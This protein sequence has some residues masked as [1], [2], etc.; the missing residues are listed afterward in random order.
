M[1][2]I[3]FCVCVREREFFDFMH[4]TQADTVLRN[5]SFNYKSNKYISS[6]SGKLTGSGATT[7]SRKFCL[8][9]LWTSKFEY[10][11]LV[12]LPL[13]ARIQSRQRW[14]VRSK[15]SMTHGVSGPDTYI[16]PTTPGTSHMEYLK[17]W[18]RAHGTQCCL[19]KT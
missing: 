14:A 9:G 11:Y 3:K 4:G 18:K 12:L 7:K 10:F 8:W 19:V 13:L 2:C 15:F 17:Q 5:L 1:I 6:S 16:S